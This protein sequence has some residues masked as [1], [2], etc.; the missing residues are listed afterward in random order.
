MVKIT[1]NKSY[2]K[3]NNC[4]D[5][6]DVV[7]LNDDIKTNFGT[8]SNNDGIKNKENLNKNCDKTY[9]NE[10]LYDSLYNYV[11]D[12]DYDF[13]FRLVSESQENNDNKLFVDCEGENLDSE[14]D[15]LRKADNNKALHNNNINNSNN[16]INKKDNHINYFG[17]ADTKENYDRDKF[18]VRNS[19]IS[20]DEIKRFKCEYENQSK[21][22]NEAGEKKFSHSKENDLD[23]KG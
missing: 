15:L 13:Y 4:E 7:E 20:F 11:D 17:Y 21:I 1:T 22:H 2:Q 12:L 9:R 5:H 23:G 8:N 19:E 3:S 16:D 14:L 18:F 10:N 6:H